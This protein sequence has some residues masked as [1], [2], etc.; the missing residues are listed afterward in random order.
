MTAIRRTVQAGKG[1]FLEDR[2]VAFALDFDD[3]LVI[4]EAVYPM[5]PSLCQ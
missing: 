5:Y 3:R 4:L 1:L 2:S